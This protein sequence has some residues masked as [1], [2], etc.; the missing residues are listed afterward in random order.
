VGDSGAPRPIPRYIATTLLAHFWRPIE[1][2]QHGALGGSVMKCLA[3]GA[4]MRLMDVRTEATTPFGIERRIFQCSSCRQ[5][6]QRLGFE[7]TRLPFS[8]SPAITPSN[9]SAIRLQRERHA[10]TSTAANAVET[11][12]SRALAPLEPH[13]SV[14][15]VVGKVSI[16]LKE[17]AREARA[18]SWTKTMEKLRSRQVAL[19]ERTAPGRTGNGELEGSGMVSTRATQHPSRSLRT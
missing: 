1:P 14:D 5:S 10:G 7:R 17:Q 3:C 18:A 4:E 12:S 8:T 11:P 16:A 13:R 6:A 15:A 2:C 9:V 19:K